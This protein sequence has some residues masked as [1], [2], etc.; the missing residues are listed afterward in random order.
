[1]LVG[2]RFQLL[3]GFAALD[4]GSR[5]RDRVAGEHRNGYVKLIPRRL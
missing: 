5:V 3:V 2:Q 1:L 4:H